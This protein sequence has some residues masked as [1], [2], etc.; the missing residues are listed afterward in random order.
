MPEKAHQRPHQN[1]QQ[2]GGEEL[3]LMVVGPGREQHHGGKHGRGNRRHSG[4]EPVH[5]VEHVERVDQSHD[6]E[7]AQHGEPGASRNSVIRQCSSNENHRGG[8]GG[9]HAQPQP[10]IELP[11]VVGQAQQHQQRAAGQQ[12]PEFH[13]LVQQAGNVRGNERGQ[14]NH[15]PLARLRERSMG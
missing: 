14:R 4:R 8:H 10:P 3:R 12:L 6:P 2:A 5:V 7:H 15:A 1:Q 9:L 11:E 13:R